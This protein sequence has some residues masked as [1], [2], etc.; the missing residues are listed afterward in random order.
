MAK[1]CIHCFA[2]AAF[3]KTVYQKKSLW[4]SMCQIV[5]SQPGPV[6]GGFFF[7]IFD[8]N[9][10]DI[11]GNND[12]QRKI[13]PVLCKYYSNRF[14]PINPSDLSHSLIINP[15]S[16]SP[17]SSHPPLALIFFFLRERGREQYQYYACTHLSGEG[18]MNFFRGLINPRSTWLSTVR[19]RSGWLAGSLGRD[20]RSGLTAAPSCLP[21]LIIEGF[22]LPA[23]R[24][25]KRPWALLG[26][27]DSS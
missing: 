27:K 26:P 2:A 13:K 9:G 24:S 20:Y 6:P 10:S 5:T 25:A 4:A 12:L 15:D 8:F 19:M 16:P 14:H 22:G 21:L 18:G 1:K 3:V 23:S 7:S 17:P 11:D